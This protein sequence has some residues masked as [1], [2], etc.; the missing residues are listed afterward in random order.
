MSAGPSPSGRKRPFI[1]AVFG[2]LERPL[3]GKADIQPGA[4]ENRFPNDRFP[5]ETGH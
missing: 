4:R 1:S 5:P 3:S 2:Q